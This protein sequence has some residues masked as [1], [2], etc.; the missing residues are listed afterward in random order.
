MELLAHRGLWIHPSE[1]NTL[2]ALKRALASGFGVET[3]VRDRQ[4][5]LVIAHD[6]AGDDSLPL[7]D[8]L[9]MYRDAGGRLPLALNIKADGLCPQIAE[10]L[11]AYG[12][13]R[14]FVFDMSVPDTLAY[15]RAGL[16]VFA[17]GSEYEDPSALMPRCAGIWLDELERPWINRA[18]VE[19]YLKSGRRVS[20]VSPELHGRP[21]QPAWEMYRPLAALYPQQLSLCTD[22]PQE[23]K[24]FFEEGTAG[25]APRKEPA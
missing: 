5:A 19:V 12:V 1:R 16:T 21:H 20:L 13:D 17:R 6:P 9:Q 2:A 10:T 14:Y 11:T 8:F 4:G 23:A 3:D 22:Y 15:F 25:A 7:K 24:A 18:V